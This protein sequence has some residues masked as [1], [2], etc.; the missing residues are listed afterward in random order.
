[1]EYI[2]ISRHNAQALVK[3]VNLKIKDGWIPQ[4]GVSTL[5]VIGGISSLNEYSQAMVK[6]D[7]K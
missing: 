4:G 1:M 3:E 6:N 5:H 7:I 2:I